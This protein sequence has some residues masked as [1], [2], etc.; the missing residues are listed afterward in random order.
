MSIAVESKT[1]SQ[2]TYTGIAGTRNN[3]QGA[4]LSDELVNDFN[5]FLEAAEAGD[6]DSMAFL[7]PKVL[8]E[9]KVNFAKLKAEVPELYEILNDKNVEILFEQA[10]KNLEILK[11]QESGAR[12]GLVGKILGALALVAS[13]LLFIAAPSPLTAAFLLVSVGTFVGSIVAEITGGTTLIE[14]MTQGFGQLMDKLGASDAMPD[15]AKSLVTMVLSIT[16]VVGGAFLATKGAT[17]MLGGVGANFMANMT[18]QTGG[19]ITKQSLERFSQC[20]MAVTE[21]AQVGSGISSSVFEHK[22]TVGGAE[23]SML[24]ADSDRVTF[25]MNKLTDFYMDLSKDSQRLDSYFGAQQS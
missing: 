21:V 1:N 16:V 4:E 22:V 7:L 3:A 5:L 17:S 6:E 20:A 19:M 23:K 15:W 25:D 10:D 13:A 24:Q 12:N 8:A 14:R 9:M 18:A 11:N 2:V